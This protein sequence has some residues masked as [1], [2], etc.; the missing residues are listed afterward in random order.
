MTT[1]VNLA[2]RRLAAA[3]TARF[4]EVDVVTVRPGEEGDPARRGDVVLAMPGTASVV[5]AVAPGARWLHVF[6]TGIDWL[7][8]EAFESAVVTCV[9]GGSAVAIAEFVLGAMLAYEKQLPELWAR[10]PEAVFTPAE[11]GGLAGRH[12]GLVGLGGIGTAVARR[13]LAFDMTVSALRRHDR[14]SPVPGVTVTTDRDAV[15]ADA[16]HLVLAAPATDRTRHLIDAGALERVKPGVHLV[17]VARGAL[18]DQDALRVALDD[19][20]VAR[21]TLDVT[22]PE[23]LPADH[24]LYRHPRVRLTGHLSWSSPVGT[25]PLTDG[26]LDNLD[27]FLHG[28]PLEGVVDPSERY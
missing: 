27:R 28:R 25:G 6:G 12:L 23:P 2:G 26:F 9:R 18:V 8:D 24:W 16:D 10:P 7:P 15:L 17:N 21:A 4:P 3:V 11:L 19:G 13:A 14:P 5:A 1:V 22:E 20:R